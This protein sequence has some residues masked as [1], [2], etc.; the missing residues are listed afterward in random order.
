VAF[1]FAGVGLAGSPVA[2]PSRIVNSTSVE[3]LEE[4]A[5]IHAANLQYEIGRSSGVDPRQPPAPTFPR[6]PGEWLENSSSSDGRP[7]SKV[8]RELH[9]SRYKVASS[10]ST[11]KLLD[12]LLDTIDD[13]LSVFCDDHEVRHFLTELVKAITEYD[14]KVDEHRRQLEEIDLILSV[15]TEYVMSRVPRK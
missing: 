1:T 3:P 6:L 14:E 4:V 9:D 5:Q 15:T 11:L 8:L 10:N 12:T 2:Q 13:S 7:L